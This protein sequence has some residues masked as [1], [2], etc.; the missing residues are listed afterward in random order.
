[1]HD[2]E[3]RFHR[4]QCLLPLDSS[5]RR[6]RLENAAMLN[7]LLMRSGAR[8]SKIA[9][10]YWYPFAANLYA[11]KV[12][13]ETIFHGG[14]YIRF[15]DRGDI[16]RYPTGYSVAIARPSPSAAQSAPTSARSSS[17]KPHKTPLLARHGHASAVSPPTYMSAPIVGQKRRSDA[18][19][20]GAPS[21][22]SASAAYTAFALTASAA[23]AG[24]AA[25]AASKKR[26]GGSPSAAAGT[27]D[28]KSSGTSG[29]ATKPYGDEDDVVETWQS[30]RGCGLI[31][32]V[33]GTDKEAL[34]VMEETHIPELLKQ[35]R[36]SPDSTIYPYMGA[37]SSIVAARKQDYAKCFHL[38]LPI[39]SV[40]KLVDVAYHRSYTMSAHAVPG[41]P[42]T[43]TITT[44]R[45]FKDN[46][47]DEEVANFFLSRVMRTPGASN[48]VILNSSFSSVLPEAAAY[49]SPQF[50]GNK[51][52]C[53]AY[54]SRLFGQY[55]EDG[56]ELFRKDLYIPF[57]I[58][59]PF[60][61]WLGVHIIAARHEIRIIEPL[62]ADYL[63]ARS[64]SFPQG[65]GAAISRSVCAALRGE[66]TRLELPDVA[67]KVTF[68]DGHALQPDGNSCG[69]YMCW[70]AL[71]LRRYGALPQAKHCGDG[72]RHILRLA[73][74]ET[75]I[76]GVLTCDD[77]IYQM[78][79]TRAATALKPSA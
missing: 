15:D 30:S 23:A 72:T 70:Y 37:T 35:C 18:G 29:K 61:H 13:R 51:V 11:D 59:K 49:C 7:N 64:S 62:G 32:D 44:T 58:Q 79:A 20:S 38:K 26:R 63:R 5:R 16:L 57:H 24:A 48:L 54:V 55:K 67:Y 45:L 75:L 21:A 12:L 69:A 3:D 40:L 22:A 41:G 17:L 27:T 33:F 6:I 76:S 4:L 66:R 68:A 34:E 47:M 8:R 43:G 25:V 65:Y 77:G 53:R 42:P 52:S 60:H 10:S 28:S 2:E 50:G 73:I 19:R 31:L 46:Y 39:M 36:E 14:S 9:T 78:C 71:C 1:M 56:A 74:A